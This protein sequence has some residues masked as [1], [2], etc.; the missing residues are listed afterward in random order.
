MAAP[1]TFTLF[2]ANLDDIKLSEL[3]GSANLRFALV[4]STYTP[5][6]TNTGNANWAGVYGWQLGVQPVIHE[7]WQ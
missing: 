7:E 5:N 4:S 3:H 1:G 2:R 6:A